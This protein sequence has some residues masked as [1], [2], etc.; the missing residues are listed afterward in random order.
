MRLVTQNSVKNPAGAGIGRLVFVLGNLLVGGIKF[1]VNV[2]TAIVCARHEC[3][4]I[5]KRRL[6]DAQ[7]RL[8]REEIDA[9]EFAE[10]K[11]QVMTSLRLMHQDY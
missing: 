3:E 4:M 9:V 7:E 11:Y 2:L 1:I 5:L 8:E 10:I 6:L